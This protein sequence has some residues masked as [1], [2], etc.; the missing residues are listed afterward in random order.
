MIEEMLALNRKLKETVSF[1]GIWNRLYS[2]QHADLMDLLPNLLGF[3]NIKTMAYSQCQMRL[4]LQPLLE[5]LTW[6]AYDLFKISKIIRVDLFQA[7]F[8]NSK[9]RVFWFLNHDLYRGFS[10]EV[11]GGFLSN[12]ETV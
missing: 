9:R 1:I 12:E 8:A 11:N 10:M 4:L 3:S 2:L 7:L 5:I 6:I